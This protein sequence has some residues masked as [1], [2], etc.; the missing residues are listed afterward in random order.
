MQCVK[1][2]WCVAYLAA[3]LDAIRHPDEAVGASATAGDA[4]NDIVCGLADGEV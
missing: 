1:E 3:A 4:V 2:V